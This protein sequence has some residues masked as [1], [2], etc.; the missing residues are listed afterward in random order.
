MTIRIKWYYT[1][2]LCGKK[3][4]MDSDKGEE[5]DKL[6]RGWGKITAE[7]GSRDTIGYEAIHR[8]KKLLCCEACI[9]AFLV[10]VKKK[11]AKP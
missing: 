2:D 10:W 5:S 3:A 11:E 4:T 1:C 7:Y 6:P 9:N 8:E